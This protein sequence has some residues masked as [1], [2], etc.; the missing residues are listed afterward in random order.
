MK[1]LRYFL[2]PKERQQGVVEIESFSVTW[3]VKTGWSDAVKIQIKAFIDKNEAKE[4][5]KQLVESAKFI[6]CWI[7]T[8]LKQN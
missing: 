2:I 1:I 6:G 5:Q 8:E 3:Q 4:F 7:S